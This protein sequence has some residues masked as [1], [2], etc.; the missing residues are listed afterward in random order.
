MDAGKSALQ[1]DG[2][3]LLKGLLNIAKGAFEAKKADAHG[4][5]NNI[6]PADVIQWA[7]CKDSQ[8]VGEA[9]DRLLIYRVPI[10]RKKEKLQEQCPM[11]ALTNQPSTRN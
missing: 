3:G 5:K 11:S 8:T 6:S 4:R 10:Q 1:G 2:G 9:L 7:G